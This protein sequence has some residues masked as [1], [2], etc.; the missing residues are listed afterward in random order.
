MGPSAG[1]PLTW[2]TILSS[3]TW[4]FLPCPDEG[5]V[6]W[7]DRA[8]WFVSEEVGLFA[9]LLVDLHAEHERFLV[10]SCQAFGHQC[11]AALLSGAW[12]FMSRR[13]VT[14]TALTV[15]SQEKSTSVLEHAASFLRWRHNSLPVLIR[16]FDPHDLWEITD[17]LSPSLSHAHGA[18]KCRRKTGPKMR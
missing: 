14:R 3:A 11:D 6:P 9:D 17:A 7:P 2:F 5:C 13:S 18:L 8:G 10:R 15:L 16:L 4:F 1:S 12:S